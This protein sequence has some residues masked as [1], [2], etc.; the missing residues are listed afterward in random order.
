[1]LA[2]PTVAAKA[3]G[4]RYAYA[5]AKGDVGSPGGAQAAME[6][7]LAALDEA[8]RLASVG[9]LPGAH[10]RSLQAQVA[11]LQ[12][13][14]GAPAGDAMATAPRD[15]AVR[16]P[17]L[18][19]DLVEL[20]AGAGISG[21]VTIEATNESPAFP[22]LAAGQPDLG[23]WWAS[24][25]LFPQLL[26]LTFARPVQAVGRVSLWATGVARVTV[27]AYNNELAW[28][29]CFELE[30]LSVECGDPAL[31]A[32]TVLY[33]AAACFPAAA[34]VF[35]AGLRRLQLAIDAGHDDFVTVHRISILGALAEL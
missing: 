5:Y 2:L 18:R 16:A 14:K 33:D 15:K 34:P 7:Q 31:A 21:L 11:S 25:G 13:N 35:P 28:P 4:D 8:A 6:E 22:A 19:S 20:V 23:T 9:L 32:E 1:M 12:P 17:P 27:R 29:P 10:A 24:T 3:G 26:T 30:S